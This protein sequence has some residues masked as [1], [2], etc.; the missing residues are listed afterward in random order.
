M[1]ES[2][3]VTSLAHR[4]AAALALAERA[5]ELGP[6]STRADGRPRTLRV[7]MGDPQADFARVMAVLDAHGLLGD[8]GR[9]APHVLLV[10]VGDHFDWGAGPGPGAAERRAQVAA[11]AERLVAWLA[12]HPAD[13]AVLLLGN[14]DLA[15][16][17]ELAGMSDARFATLQAESDAAYRPDAPEAEH[18]ALEAE[19]R[20]RWPG[21]PGAELAARDFSAYR[22]A[23]GR[24]VAHLLRARRFRTAWAASPDVLV[25]HAGVTRA[26]LE[27]ARLDP[28]LRHS[29]F[30]VEAALERALEAALAGWEPGTPLVVPGLHR[31]GARDAEGTGIFYHRP[32]VLPTP[33]FFTRKLLHV[34]AFLKGRTQT[35]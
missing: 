30:E 24:W 25:L 8:D 18:A 35:R 22:E 21:L 9:L 4:T 3:S 15:R 20:A 23:Q 27:V 29:A 16:V 34:L 33:V 13:Q 17:G 28:E 5:L 32:S 26:D 11:S 14:H 10:S 31:P 7:V 19:F 6:H 1:A 12:H 2:A